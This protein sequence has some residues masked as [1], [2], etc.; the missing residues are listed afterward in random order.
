MNEF[1]GFLLKILIYFRFFLIDLSN[2]YIPHTEI[3]VISIDPAESQRSIGAKTR[4]LRA[5]YFMII[6]NSAY[7]HQDTSRNIERNCT[8]R[9]FLKLEDTGK[10]ND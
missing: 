7:L 10:E 5:F 3:I 1:S 6:L 8:K 2:I 9:Q 4:F